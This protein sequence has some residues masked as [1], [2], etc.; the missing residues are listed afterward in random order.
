[1][2]SCIFFFAIR[3]LVAQWRSDLAAGFTGN[4]LSVFAAHMW[5]E[6]FFSPGFLVYCIEMHANGEEYG[7]NF[8]EN[9]VFVENRLKQ[10]MTSGGQTDCWR[11][12]ET[13]ADG[14]TVGWMDRRPPW[15][16]GSPLRATAIITEPSRTRSA[17]K[18]VISLRRLS[19]S[20]T[21]ILATSKKSWGSKAILLCHFIL[22]FTPC[23]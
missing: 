23:W 18:V 6:A 3:G 22:A 14:R 12:V 19:Q 1:M 4:F 9:S 7:Q 17:T 20:A 8:T 2:Q 21:N 13:R 11:T 16:H 10:M 5:I 15:L